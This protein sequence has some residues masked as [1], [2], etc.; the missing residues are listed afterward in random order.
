MLPPWASGVSNEV[1]SPPLT[2]I[3]VSVTLGP[4]MSKTRSSPFWETVV[5]PGP[6]LDRHR[7]VLKEVEVA[8]CVEVLVR[9]VD[10]RVLLSLQLDRV[11]GALPLGAPADRLVVVGG[12]DR[13]AQRAIPVVVQL[14]VG[15]VDVDRRR[16]RAAPGS[17]TRPRQPRKRGIGPPSRSL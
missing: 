9:G 13:L 6:S 14:V 4:N 1:T 15:D 11:E 10:D 8:A 17:R 7:P 16:A 2:R 3:P 12:L 5:S